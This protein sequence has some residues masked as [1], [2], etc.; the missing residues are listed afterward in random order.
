MTLFRFCFKEK[1]DFED[2]YY[3]DYVE[4]KGE[5]VARFANT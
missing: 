5:V 4:K 2:D 1:N 3:Y